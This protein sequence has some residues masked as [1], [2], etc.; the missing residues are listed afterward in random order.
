MDFSCGG[1]IINSRYIL[2]AAHCFYGGRLTGYSDIKIEE[3]RLGDW[4]LETDP[5]KSTANLGKAKTS[6]P[7][8]K[9]KPGKIILHEKYNK[10]AVWKGYDIALIRLDEPIPPDSLI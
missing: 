7:V 9:R 8:I 6:N 4:N 10:T 5:D 2:T 1:S 3:I